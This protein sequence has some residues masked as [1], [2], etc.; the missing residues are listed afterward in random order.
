L[1]AGFPLCFWR[2]VGW[3]VVML[4][5]GDLVAGFPHCFRWGAV[6]GRKLS[7]FRFASGGV[8]CRAPSCRFSTLLPVGGRLVGGDVAE[9]RFTCR[10]ST[11]LKAFD[12]IAADTFSLAQCVQ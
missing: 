11:L 10:F 2:G 7:V 4:Q 12:E 5:N 6:P 3:L 9:R 1:V 8:L